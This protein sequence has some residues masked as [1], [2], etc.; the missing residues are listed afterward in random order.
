MDNSN[1]KNKAPSD[2]E[3]GE[4]DNLTH[5]LGNDDYKSRNSVPRDDSESP[6]LDGYEAQGNDL[7]EEDLSDQARKKKDLDERFSLHQDE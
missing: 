4:G 2:I 6:L 1:K 5:Y 7:E 3:F